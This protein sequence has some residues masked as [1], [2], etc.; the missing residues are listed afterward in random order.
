MIIFHDKSQLINAASKRTCFSVM[1]YLLSMMVNNKMFVL[2]LWLS[3]LKLSQAVCYNSSESSP[4]CNLCWSND[5][6]MVSCWTNNS[7]VQPTNCLTYCCGLKYPVSVPG[8]CQNNNNSSSSG[9]SLATI[10]IIVFF[11]IP[12][13]I[14]V[15]ML[16]HS[17]VVHRYQ[18]PVNAARPVRSEPPSSSV[19]LEEHNLEN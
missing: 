15:I 17:C 12:V 16:I 18:T 7:S 10:L 13:V 1:N 9:L 5:Q 14:C 11:S 19:N 8:N 2:I 4:Q 3:M 6:N